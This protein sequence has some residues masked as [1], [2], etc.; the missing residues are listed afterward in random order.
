MNLS[1]DSDEQLRGRLVQVQRELDDSRLRLV[2]RQEERDAIKR[3]LTARDEAKRIAALPPVDRSARVLTS[4]ETETDRPDYREIEP[5]TGMQRSYVVLSAEERAKGFVRPVRRTYTHI[6]RSVC[7]KMQTLHMPRA[8]KLGG[9]RL[10]CGR[11]E[12]HNDEC[13]CWEELSQP[14]HAIAERTHRLGG[15]GAT[16]TMGIAL[17]ETYARDPKFYN[18]TFC[19]TCRAHFGLDQFVWTGT[20]EQ[21]GS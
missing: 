17:A 7:A 13:A 18:G 21:V 10:I 5:S 20:D 12:G 6:G 14:E 16:T 1:G 2:N 8:P 9:P 15:C 4:G 3:E 19:A 11:P